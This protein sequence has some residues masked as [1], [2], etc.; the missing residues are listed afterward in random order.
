MRRE[1][2][3]QKDVVTDV[4]V[5]AFSPSHVLDRTR[6]GAKR[7]PASAGDYQQVVSWMGSRR[8]MLR[9]LLGVDVV[10]EAEWGEAVWSAKD[11]LGVI[12]KRLVEFNGK[13]APVYIGYSA[14]VRSERSWMICLQGH[15]SGMHISLGVDSTQERWQIPVA[16]DRDVARWCMAAGFNVLCLEQLS[17][18][19]RREHVLKKTHQHP[20]QDAAMHRLALGHTL[21]GERVAEVQGVVDLIRSNEPP[22]IRIGIIGNSMGGTVAMYSHALCKNID[23]IIAAGCV[24]Q[25]DDALISGSGRH[26]TDLYV[27]GLVE[28]FDCSDIL[29][30]AAP[31]LTILVYGI[32]DQIFP[33]KGFARAFSEAKEGFRRLDADKYLHAVIGFGGHRHYRVLTLAAIAKFPEVFGYLVTEGI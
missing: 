8:E 5:G 23:F 11:R 31:K 26:C 28:H 12:S 19:E 30:L 17:L 13:I 33:I 10:P 9:G 4:E 18:G 21:L 20:C 6:I 14:Q 25:F 2:F 3:E 29:M 16:G 1:R 15:G 24:S 22:G 7:V 27:P 32:G